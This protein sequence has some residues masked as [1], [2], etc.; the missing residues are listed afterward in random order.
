MRH[1]ILSSTKQFE[2]FSE[3][4]ADLVRNLINKSID[5]FE[6]LKKILIEIDWVS[7][8]LTSGW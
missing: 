8:R 6:M 1:N 3:D 2:E 7:I 4:D 5:M